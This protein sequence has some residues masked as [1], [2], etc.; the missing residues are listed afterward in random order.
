ME[1]TKHLWRAILILVVVVGGYLLTRGF[2]VPKGFGEYGYYRG[3]NL[4]EQMNVRVPRYGT[5][6]ESCA[7]CHDDVAETLMQTPHRVINCETCHAPLRTH[8]EYPSIEEFLADPS[9]FD[10]TAPMEIHSAQELCIKCHDHQLAKPPAF[11][12]VVVVEHLKE[13]DM[14]LGPN[15][16]L[17]CHDPHDPEM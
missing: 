3:D 16:C 2:L 9:Q 4:K 7:Y 14:K 13:M 6:V 10:R 1:H 12:T 11:K 5:G 15:V 17:E 8:V